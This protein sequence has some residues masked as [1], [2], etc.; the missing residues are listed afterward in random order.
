MTPWRLA[1][2]LAALAAVAAW[3]V[4]VIPASA[5]EMTVGATL[6]PGLVTG[7]LATLVVLYGLSAWR[8]RQPDESAPPG[9]EPLPGS[10]LRL[11]SLLGGGIA[12]MATVGPLG[13]VTAGTLCGL[14]VARAFDAR[15]GLKSLVICG[16]L[17]G[18]FWGVFAQLL[19]VGRGPAVRWPW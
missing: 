15:V 12:F 8:G 7:L 3:Q 16:M 14:G 1:L 9:A 2:L 18:V 5:I 13:F 17:A 10:S 11:I 6:V 19:G 4:T